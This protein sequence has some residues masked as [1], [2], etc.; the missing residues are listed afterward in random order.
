[1]LRRPKLDTTPQG[2]THYLPGL[3]LVGGQTGRARGSAGL[4]AHRASSAACGCRWCSLG[5]APAEPFPASHCPAASRQVSGKQAARAEGRGL[6]SQT[7]AEPSRAWRA[8]QQADAAEAE[9][10]A[11]VLLCRFGV[12]LATSRHHRLLVMCS[13]PRWQPATAHWPCWRLLSTSSA[14]CA[15][16]PP[17]PARSVPQQPRPASTHTATPKLQRT[18]ELVLAHQSMPL[19]TSELQICSGRRPRPVV[20]P[21]STTSS[22]FGGGAERSVREHG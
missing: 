7:Q 15:T 1:M 8:K 13:C 2:G 6:C 17:G 10:R 5:Q 21:G 12:K 14:R 4:G 18:A 9:A 11:G 19:S 22:S 3:A 20:S 16:S